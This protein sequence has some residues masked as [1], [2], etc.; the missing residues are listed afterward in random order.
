[1][2]DE[3][4]LYG[5]L[6]HRLIDR[7]FRTNGAFALRGD[8]LRAWFLREFAAVVAEEGAV[9][10]MPG[11]RGDYERLRSAMERTIAEFQRQFAAAGIDAVEPERALAGNFTGG[12]LEGVADLVVR[13]SSG[14]RAI[15]DM[16]WSGGTYHQDRLAKNRHL[17]LAL[18]A[19]ML[20][21]ET[22]AWPQVAYFILE[23]SRLL[24]PDTGFFPEARAVQSGGPGSTA[25]LWDRFVAA[26][27]W[28]RSQ[29]DAG[30]IEVAAEGIEP[31][32]ESVAPPDALEPEQLQQEYDDYR[33]LAGWEG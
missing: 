6:A 25:V 12:E 28:R 7:L 11:R 26:W 30:L 9:L 1:V 18:Y 32:A 19:E 22:G 16:K 14:Q 8:A 4:L 5:N 3:N 21:R 33:W 10:L 17:Q 2:A 24:A 23:A 27:N 29:V 31:T 15:V 20:R 13:N